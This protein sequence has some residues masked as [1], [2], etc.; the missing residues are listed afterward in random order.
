M[1][2]Y[3]LHDVLL[4]LPNIYTKVLDYVATRLI[5]VQSCICTLNVMGRI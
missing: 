3:H 4:L 2:K 1:T 5:D